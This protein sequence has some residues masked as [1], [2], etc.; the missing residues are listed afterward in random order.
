M[1]ISFRFKLMLSYL[2]LLIVMGGSA[3]FYLNNTLQSSVISTLTDNLHS[4]TR[5]AALMLSRNLSSLEQD[6]PPLAISL[7]ATLSER[8]TIISADGRVVGDSEVKPADLQ[9]LE[10]HSGRPEIQDAL[11]KRNR[12]GNPVLLYGQT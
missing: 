4:Q 9:A 8:V 2:L 3:Y 11:S 1:R 5:L 7:G 10:N 12:Y 6:A